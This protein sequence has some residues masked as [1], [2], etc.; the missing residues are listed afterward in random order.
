[1]AKL[2]KNFKK[3]IGRDTHMFQVEGDDFYE[4]IMEERNLS[5]G[6]VKECGLCGHDDL[7][8]GAHLAQ[9]KHKYVTITCNKC[10]GYVNFGKQQEDTNVYFLRLKKDDKGQNLRDQSGKTMIDWRKYEPPVK[11]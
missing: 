1:M 4:V 7:T 9:K 11:D 3:V 5:F 6:D 2:K 10:R 8:L